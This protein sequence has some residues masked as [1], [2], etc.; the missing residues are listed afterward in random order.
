[1]NQEAITRASGIIN[2]KQDYV[3]GGMDGFV[4]LSLIDE[5]GHPTSSA[6]TLSKSDGIKW[7]SFLG[8]TGSNKAKRIKN[9]NKA[10]V[11][12]S[13][14]GYNITLVGT[15]ETLI[16]P[17]KK[18]PHWQ[19]V[20][21]ENHGAIDCPDHCAFLFTTERYSIYFA[22]DNSVAEGTL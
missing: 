1:M 18:K 4:V 16:D 8:G 21:T 14:S 17:A 2:S 6:I 7:L 5:Q 22:D 3:G 9:C 15:I 13:T 20:F 19:D 11:N 10:G 12:I